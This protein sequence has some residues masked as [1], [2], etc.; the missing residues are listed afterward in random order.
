MA[1]QDPASRVVDNKQRG[2]FEL[3]EN[4]L[5][6]FADYRE[7][8]DVLLLPHVE[9]PH[10]LRGTG[11]AG[12]LMQGLLDKVRSDGRKVVPLCPYAAA[13]IRRN[14]QYEDLVA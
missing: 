11:A 13:Y 1:E 3:T 5:T 4:G 9:A 8:G 2:R 10:A 7:D 12:R 14:P 6:A